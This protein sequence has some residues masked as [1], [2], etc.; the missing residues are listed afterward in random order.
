M[1]GS[2]AVF[3]NQDAGSSL[4]PLGADILLV[5]EREAVLLEAVPVPL[6]VIDELLRQENVAGLGERLDTCSDNDDV[7]NF[8]VLRAFEKRD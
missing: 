4:V 8:R 1:L 6:R 7:G 2:L 5:H 3:R